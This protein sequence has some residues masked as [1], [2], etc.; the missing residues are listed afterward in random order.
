MKEKL[1]NSP[2]TSPSTLNDICHH[3]SA[4]HSR[5]RPIMENALF[6]QTFWQC[7]RGNVSCNLL[8][9]K[10]DLVESQWAMVFVPPSQHG[11][12]RM[13]IKDIDT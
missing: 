13:R 7:M 9:V 3:V 12:F 11:A 2:W 10:G 6:W 1:V 8:Y 5:G 4:L